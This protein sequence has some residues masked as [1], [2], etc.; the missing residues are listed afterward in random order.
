MHFLYSTSLQKVYPQQ[1][2]RHE[3]KYIKMS[4]LREV[5]IKIEVHKYVS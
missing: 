3:E 5:G 4:I 1:R 2:V